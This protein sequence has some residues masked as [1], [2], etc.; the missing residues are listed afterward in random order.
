MIRVPNRTPPH[1]RGGPAEDKASDQRVSAKSRSS[2]R[3]ALA[4]ASRT[5]VGRMVNSVN[6]VSSC[7]TVGCRMLSISSRPT[8]AYSG[9][10]R[11]SH[12]LDSQ[13]VSTGTGIIRR[14]RPRCRAYSCIRSLYETLS[15]PPI[16][17]MGFPSTGRS[18]AASRYCNR[19]SMPIGWAGT[20]T[21]RGV[22]IMGSRST[23]ARII[24]KERLPDPMTMEARNSITWT[25]EARSTV[26]T[27]CRL[28]RCGESAPLPT[29]NPPK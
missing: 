11:P 17:R 19:S 29:P 13:G 18:S 12:R 20:E 6:A 5:P 10:T 15:D 26:P 23:S 22:I 3:S 7:T 25:P 21:Q 2:F 1:R 9:V 16:S 24:S 27:S 14:R 8:R 28:R 4:M